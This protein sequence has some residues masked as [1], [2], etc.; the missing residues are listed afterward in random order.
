MADFPTITPS[1]RTFAIGKVANTQFIALDG[2][3]KSVRK[4]SS[5]VGHS[6][7]L[8]FDRLTTTDFKNIVGHYQVHGEFQQFAL[9]S[10]ITQG[11][12]IPI[13][14][15]YLW[16][17]ANSPQFEFTAGTITCSVELMLLPPNLT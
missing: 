17:Y 2:G 3:Q 6:L 11:A 14:S 4:S 8:S 9:P 10:V 15:S 12:T 7:S 1:I 16:K 5:S 13:P